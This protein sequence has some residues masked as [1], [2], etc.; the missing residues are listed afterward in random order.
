MKFEEWRKK[1][2][3][4]CRDSLERL[5]ELINK[6]KKHEDN[7]RVNPRITKEW[8]I[9]NGMKRDLSYAANWLK[10]G[11]EPEQTTDPARLSKRR[12]EV[13]IDD[14][15]RVH[16]ETDD[17]TTVW[18]GEEEEFRQYWAEY[19]EDYFEE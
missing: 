10:R 18:K 9:L 7:C 4:I 3:D 5:E 12:R 8:R 15:N 16:Y 1:H 17:L 6:T 14:F 11:R 19:M 2:L 13:L